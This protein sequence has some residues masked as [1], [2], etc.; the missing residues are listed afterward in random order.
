MAQVEH[1]HVGVGGGV[2]DVGCVFV[3]IFVDRMMLLVLVE[4]LMPLLK[5]LGASLDRLQRLL[6]LSK[7]ALE[8][9]LYSYVQIAFVLEVLDFQGG[10]ATVAGGMRAPVRLGGL[11][12]GM[13]AEVH[14]PLPLRLLLELRLA[15]R[16]AQ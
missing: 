6:W 3:D 12:Q 11:P 5:V 7:L 2:G 10:V 9:L 8:I 16:A 1:I 13:D 15:N 4:G 14:H